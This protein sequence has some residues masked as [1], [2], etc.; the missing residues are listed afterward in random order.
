MYN[1]NDANNINNNN[2][3]YLFQRI[4][5]LIQHF[6]SIMFHETFPVEDVV[7]T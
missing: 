6:I 4:I 5:M 1:N 3:Y 2:Y 7:D